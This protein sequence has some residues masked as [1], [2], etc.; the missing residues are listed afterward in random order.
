M[1]AIS[2]NLSEHDIT[3]YRL[4]QEL[5]R[6]LLLEILLAEISTKNLAGALIDIYIYDIIMVNIINLYPIIVVV[7]LI[8][9]E[10]C[11]IHLYIQM[12]FLISSI[13]NRI[14]LYKL[15]LIKCHR[16]FM[17][18]LLQI[19]QIISLDK[20]DNIT[21]LNLKLENMFGALLGAAIG[22]LIWLW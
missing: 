5:M 9:L 17:R 11:R 1:N 13:H 15:V 10:S 7:A 22:W 3:Q 20:L 8:D 4:L 6:N 18:E 21:I 19:R 12:Q 14:T 16:L 2:I